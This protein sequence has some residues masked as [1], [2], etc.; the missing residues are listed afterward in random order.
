M[1]NYLF[2]FLLAWLLLPL[3]A[4][5]ITAEEILASILERQGVSVVSAIDC[6]KV[7]DADAESYGQ[8]FFTEQIDTSGKEYQAIQEGFPPQVLKEIYRGMGLHN[9]GCI[10]AD[11]MAINA[12]MAISEGVSASGGKNGLVSAEKMNTHRLASHKYIGIIATWTTIVWMFSVLGFAV[13]MIWVTSSKFRFQFRK[14]A[15]G[16]FDQDDKALSILKER[17]AR[18][19]IT[20]GEFETTR[21][22]ILR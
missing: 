13:F 17:F 15:E 1:R 21:K 9:L 20:K 14:M 4:F 10:G 12:P 2:L 8:A 11:G 3:S 5:A 7:D 19:E 16:E 18:G 22:E 6:T